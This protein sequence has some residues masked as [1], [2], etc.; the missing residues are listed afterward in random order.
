MTK[1]SIARQLGN[2]IVAKNRNSGGWYGPH[3]A[4]ASRAIQER[5]PLVDLVLEVRDARVRNWFLSFASV[6][7]LIFTWRLRNVLK[8]FDEISHLH[9]C[10]FSSSFLVTRDLEFGSFGHHWVEIYRGEGAKWHLHLGFS[11]FSRE[12]LLANELYIYMLTRL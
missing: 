7:G 1:A 12:L 9:F 10:G 2:A 11:K 4:A 3:M 5:I 6:M 8:L